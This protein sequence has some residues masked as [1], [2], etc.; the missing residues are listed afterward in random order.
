MYY[1][2]MEHRRP[3]HVPHRINAGHVDHSRGVLHSRRKHLVPASYLH[4]LL[5]WR[6]SFVAGMRQLQERKHSSHFVSICVYP[7]SKEPARRPSA[8]LLWKGFRVGQTNVDLLIGHGLSTG[9]HQRANAPTHP[10]RSSVH[11]P[12]IRIRA[13][14][15]YPQ[16][17]LKV[18][19]QGDA[20][21]KQSKGPKYDHVH[22]R[23][24]GDE[25]LEHLFRPARVM[26]TEQNTRV[27]RRGLPLLLHQSG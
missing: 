13:T 18:A 8:V 14:R 15:G 7:T 9:L 20:T 27:R 26:L 21:S 25:V 22:S 4:E 11:L 6:T 24:R 17:Y 16:S 12:H 3:P 19:S 1:Q 5:T 23:C 2:P 10:H